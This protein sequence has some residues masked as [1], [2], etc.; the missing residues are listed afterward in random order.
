MLIRTTMENEVRRR[1]GWEK[2]KIGIIM[3]LR[4]GMIRKRIGG[5][6]GEEQEKRVMRTYI[7]Y[8]VIVIIVLI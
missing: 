3:I 6:E 1:R 8:N 2:G 5:T 7:E 4:I